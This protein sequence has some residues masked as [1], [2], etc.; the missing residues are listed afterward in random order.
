[1]ARL[2]RTAETDS[3]RIAPGPGCQAAD[4]PVGP[5]RVVV[6]ARALEYAAAIFRALGDPARLRLLTVLMVGPR[7]VTQL[8]AELNDNLPA[9]SQRLKLLKSERIVSSRRQGKH[10]F[11]SLDDEHIAQLI[12]TGLSHA[13]EPVTTALAGGGPRRPTPATPSAG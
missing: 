5:L 1:M 10:I 2:R 4:H 11:Y 6:E 7:C 13:A 8:A 9:V 12:S 3:P